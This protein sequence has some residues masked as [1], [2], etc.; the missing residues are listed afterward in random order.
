MLFKSNK[1]NLNSHKETQHLEN[2]YLKENNETKE[3]NNKV[4]TLKESNETK[5]LVT[6][7][8]S[9]DLYVRF[10]AVEKLE[11]IKWK[12]KTNKE[13]RLFNSAKRKKNQFS[14]YLERRKL[15]DYDAWIKRLCSWDESLQIRALEN[16]E[17][18]NW[19]PM[20]QLEREA[21]N[22]A[23]LAKGR[24]YKS[25]NKYPRIS[26]IE[27]DSMSGSEFE[28]FLADLFEKM[29]YIVNKTPLS[30]DQ[31]ADMIMNN[32]IA[33]QAKNYSSKVGN[34]SVQEVVASLKYYNVNEGWVVTNNEFTKPAI[35]LA[36]ANNVKLI[37]KYELKRFVQEHY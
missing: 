11:D 35:K 4:N 29:G 36:R 22:H 30:G 10:N 12:P 5:E 25:L 18:L 2:D 28:D 26:M 34:K 23:K 21:Y 19:K 7:L 20:N 9:D 16:L 6:N 32:N 14:E 33:V 24:H 31:G 1:A 13:K 8:N 37:D 3:L 15:V 17:E 27:I